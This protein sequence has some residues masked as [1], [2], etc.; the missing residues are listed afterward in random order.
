MGAMGR[1]DLERQCYAECDS[2]GRKPGNCLYEHKGS[3]S[4]VVPAKSKGIENYKVFS[5]RNI[6]GK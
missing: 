4:V 5:E 6:G 2:G 3:H 1:G